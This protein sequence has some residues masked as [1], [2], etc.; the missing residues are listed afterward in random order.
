MPG[1]ISYDFEHLVGHIWSQN[2]SLW[3]PFGTSNCPPGPKLD[4]KKTS[5]FGPMM[6]D[7]IRGPKPGVFVASSFCSGGSLSPKVSQRV[8]KGHHFGSKSCPK[9]AQG[10]PLGH[11]VGPRSS[12]LCSFCTMANAGAHH[13]WPRQRQR[14]RQPFPLA[15]IT[16][17]IAPNPL[18]F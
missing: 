10:R 15:T 17:R 7:G 16:S 8:A 13:L 11:K 5:G 2:G 1:S 12:K 4:A 6:T 14:Q 3:P 9:S 18:V